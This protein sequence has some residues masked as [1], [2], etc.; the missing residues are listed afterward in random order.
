M[1]KLSGLVDLKALHEAESD[2]YTHIGYGKYKE[3][4]KEDD[5]DAPTFKK[6]GE[7]FVPTSGGDSSSSDSP[8]KDTPKVNIFDKPKDE[9][10]SDSSS[11]PDYDKYTNKSQT[12]TD[13]FKG[14]LSIDDL[15]KVAKKNFDSEIATERD[16]DGF[17]NN[18]F[19]QDVMADEHGIDKDTLISKVKDLKAT[20]FGGDKEEPKSKVDLSK[21]DTS[22]ETDYFEEY[23]ELPDNVGKLYDKYF[24]EE[25]TFDY[26]ELANIRDEFEKEGWTFEFG[27]DGDPYELKPKVKN[28]SKSTRLTSLLPEGLINEG[29]RSQVGV[30]KG[31]KII[32][33]YVHYDGYP[34]NMKDGLKKHMKDEKDVMTLIK[35]GGARGIYDDK[36]I[37]YY[38]NMKPMK[39]DVKNI[40][41]YVKNA[42]NEA[43]A[44]YVYLYNTADK[45]WYYA[46]T[47]DDTRLKK[48]F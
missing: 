2:K 40:D 37:E 17:L 14:D 27:L 42:G 32:S 20:M 31:G 18:K 3:K 12:M 46:K 34:S 43:S 10:K 22:G 25:P 16:L 11:E 5:K 1:I 23:D 6:D 26:K 24:S 33:V 36:E 29:T 19:M 44:D 38:G 21:Y 35:K 28:E 7:K 8:K 4:G 30:I 39:G 15:Q 45:K 41:D 13:F 48:L 9:P 47:Y